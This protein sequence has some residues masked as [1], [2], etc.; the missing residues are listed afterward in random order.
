M[1][2][3]NPIS[4]SY[5]NLVT[6]LGTSQDKTRY[7]AFVPDRVLGPTELAVQYEGDALTAR[8][9]DRLVDDATRVDWHL[10]GADKRYDW[11][12][13]KSKLDD[14][15]AIAHCGDAWRWSRLYGGALVIMAVN[16]GRKYS[17]PLDMSNIRDFTGLSVVDSSIATPVGFVAGLG[18]QAFSKPQQYQ[19][20]VPL[21]KETQRVVHASRV[22][23]FDGMRVPASRMI[24]N[25]GW[26]PS[27]IQ[28]CHKSLRGLS[29][30]MQYAENLLQEISVMVLK[31]PGLSEKLCGGPD[32]VRQVK[33]ML[34]TLRWGIDVLHMMGL[35]SEM[36]FQEVK[37]SVDGVASLI[38]K[39]EQQAVRDTGI[40]RIILTGE[41]PA[42]L[43]ADSRGEVRAWY[44]HVE[45]DRNLVLTPAL[46]RILEVEFALRKRRGEVVPAEWTIGYDPLLTET[47]EAQAASA[48]Q[49][50]L[51]M[52][53]LIMEGIISPDEARAQLI[54]QGIIEVLPTPSFAKP[55]EME[56]TSDPESAY[57]GTGE[58]VELGS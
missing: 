17:E 14:L 48:Q 27:M 7:S 41:Q 40:P 56:P 34:E 2:E 5:A 45:S 44:D 3:S 8:V 42:G 25:G 16:D 50:A 30:A 24:T 39:F 28:R 37:R 23:R 32:N 21:G 12:S 36:E 57:Y 22:I 47:K 51:T 55:S 49:W 38:D 4:D 52:Q 54:N 26:S 43:N 20:M 31:I 6:G 1:S 33:G 13:V 53:A 11:G 18:S 46:N 19:I 29:T 15:Q 10:H 35:D 9:V 58:E